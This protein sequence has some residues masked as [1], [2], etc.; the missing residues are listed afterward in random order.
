MANIQANLQND[1]NAVNADGSSA[2]LRGTRV[3]Q[4]FTSDWRHE[5]LLQGNMYRFTVGTITAGGNIA[6]VTG[7]G[8]VTTINEDQPEFGF[9]VPAGYTLIPMRIQVACQVDLDADVEEGSIILWAD[10]AATVPTDGTKTTVNPVN[11]LHGATDY[12]GTAFKQCTADLT[13]PTVSEILM[14]KTVQLSEVTGA[15]E[16]VVTLDLLYEPLMPPH[17][18]GP[19]SVYGA[20]GGTAAVPGLANVEFAAV[21]NARFSR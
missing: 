6:Q 11:M 5:L 16:A 20:W 15:G 14:F 9:G 10:L 19:C 1:G 7:G 3:G 17:F 18:I 4:L 12:P 2:D 21:P 13:D 8:A